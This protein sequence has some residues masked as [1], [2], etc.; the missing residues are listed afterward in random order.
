[1]LIFNEKLPFGLFNVNP[2]NTYVGYIKADYFFN[3]VQTGCQNMEV[4]AKKTIA[5][6]IVIE[7]TQ[8]HTVDSTA[9]DPN[10]S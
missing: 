7:Q 4:R 8:Q 10:D 2:Q 3:F 5:L 1:M 6:Q 9:I